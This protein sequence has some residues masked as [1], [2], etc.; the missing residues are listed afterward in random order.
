MAK[1]D[2]HPTVLRYRELEQAGELP[3]YDEVLDADW[4]KQLVLD[5]GA[6]DVGFVDINDP[7]V[8]DQ[9]DK[10]LEAYPKTKSLISIIGR[11]NRA[12]VQS[13]LRT[14]ANT[15]FHTAGHEINDISHS[16]VRELEDFGIGA[17]NPPMGFPMELSKF[18]DENVFVVSH[19]PIAEAAGLGVMGIH[20]NVIHPKYGN[21]VLLG[22]ILL[23]RE[24]SEY[25]SRLD[26]NPCFECKLCVAV[27]P[28]GAIAADGHFN[29]S[30]CMN[31]NYKEFFGGFVEWAEKM[32][33]TKNKDEYRK[34][35]SV[36][37]DATRW[38]SL[39]NGANYNAAY[40]MAVCPAG[41]DVIG[42]YLQNK[43]QFMQETVKPFQK[44]EETLYITKN[45]DAMAY[46]AK[47][48]PHKTIQ[49][50][51]GG[52]VPQ[53]V[54]GF[55]WGTK[56]A[57][58]RNQADGLDATFHF[59]FTGEEAT[60][61]TFVIKDKKLTVEEGLV[62]T[63]DIEIQIDGSDW[64]DLLNKRL[65]LVWAV[66]SRKLKIKGDRAL[67]FRFQECFG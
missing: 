36:S 58:Q 5:A 60:E 21:F 55:L 6:D 44:K 4:L 7:A 16:V 41:D 32:A 46:A 8:D 25:G 57:F 9:R 2:R 37:E 54:K 34:D 48:Y 15:E 53:S 52:L 63:A 10:I 67:L 14:I 11:M 23:S 26:Y 13:L 42:P 38:Q 20:R 22:T 29:A 19:K 1:I 64:V 3:D 12:P 24:V 66:L 65:N 31:H 62:G 18:P 56:I 30:A 33:D 45:S 50:V 35:V 59:R 47:R 49:V 61:Q 39:S 17:V 43:R 40:C 51:E 27:C 28:V